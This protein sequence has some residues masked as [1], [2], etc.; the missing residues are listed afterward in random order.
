MGDIDIRPANSPKGLKGG[1]GDND[2]KRYKFKDLVAALGC[3]H[4]TM[5]KYSDILKIKYQE[6]SGKRTYFFMTNTEY[7]NLREKVNNRAISNDR[8][9]LE[10][11]FD[12]FNMAFSGKKFPAYG[13]EFKEISG[14]KMIHKHRM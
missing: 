7:S 14:K 5:R 1:Y 8:D 4:H 6:T 11:C 2:R 9:Q 3:S 10:T 13:H 12:A